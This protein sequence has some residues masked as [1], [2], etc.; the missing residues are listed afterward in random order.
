MLVPARITF[1]I[2]CPQC[3]RL[4]DAA[5]SLFDLSGQRSEKLLCSCGAHRL[6][7]AVRKGQVRLQVPCYLCEGLHFFYYRPAQFWSGELHDVTC[8]V[9]DLQLGVFGDERAVAESD[10][11]GQSELEHL[12]EEGAFEEY[13]D[14]P[15][16]MY[17]SLRYVHDLAEKGNLSCACGNRKV[18]VDIFPDRLELGCPDCKAQ[19]TILAATEEDMV[20]LRRIRRIEVGSEAQGMI[21]EHKP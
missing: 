18:E 14:N 21:Q 20:G 17:E 19:R 3:G 6:T 1:A 10:Q 12:L 5:I 8:T 9:T 2:R 16:V 11:Q 4:D 7:I 15:G 13:F